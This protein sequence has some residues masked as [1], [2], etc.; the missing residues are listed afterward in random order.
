MSAV[1]EFSR[2]IFHCSGWIGSSGGSKMLSVLFSEL[3]ESLQASAASIRA[4]AA[5]SGSVEGGT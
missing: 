2:I 4:M 1:F 5:S 3:A